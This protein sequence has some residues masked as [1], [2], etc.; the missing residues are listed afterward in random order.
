M[1]IPYDPDSSKSLYHSYYKSQVGGSLPAFSGAR[2]QQKGHGF[3]SNLLK[4]AMPLLKQGATTIGKELFS[5]GLNVAKDV[6][7]G[8]N[9]KKSISRNIR[10]SGSNLLGKISANVNKSSNAGKARKRKATKQLIRG[11]KK[12]R[13]TI[14]NDIF[15]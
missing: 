8:E 14:T 2:I 6:L 15:I 5:S 9:F 7:G 4:G 12:S 3:F 10:Q 13:R 1:P 11:N